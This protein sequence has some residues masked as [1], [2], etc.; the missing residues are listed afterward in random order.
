MKTSYQIR[1]FSK[2][3]LD[4]DGSDFGDFEKLAASWGEK[5]SGKFNIAFSK[6]EGLVRLY[7]NILANVIHPVQ[8]LI[9]CI[10]IL[11]K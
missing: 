7:T 10:F 1:K 4:F 11:K 2:L 5:E 3:Y 9:K 8:S 6:I